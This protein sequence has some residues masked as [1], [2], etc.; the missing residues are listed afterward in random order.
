M[1]K[2]LLGFVV[3][4]KKNDCGQYVVTGRYGVGYGVMGD[5]VIQSLFLHLVR[6]N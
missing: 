6:K 2:S 4:G 3:G 1:K 5:G